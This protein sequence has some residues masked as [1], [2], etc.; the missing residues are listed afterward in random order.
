MSAGSPSDVTEPPGARRIRAACSAGV[1]DD[2]LAA[3]R[4][5]VTDARSSMLGAPVDLAIVFLGSAYADAVEVVLE[6]VVGELRP[7]HV[8]AVT[9]QG[10]VS[11][12]AEVE[13]PTALSVWAAALPGATLEPL[14][15]DPPIGVAPSGAPGWRPPADP[16]SAV[17]LLV[18]PFTFPSDAFL[19]WLRQAR[20]GLPVSGGLASGS[21]RPG[22]NRLHLDGETYRDGA[23]G[24]AIGGGIRARTLVSQGCRPVGTSYVVTDA[25]RNLIRSL[26]GATPVDRVR[27]AFAAATSADRELMRSGL[28]IGAVID[29][30]RTEFGRGDFLVRAVIGAD[31]ASGAIAVGDRVDVG[32]TVQ[33]HVRDAASATEDLLALLSRFGPVDDGAAGLLFTC[34]GRGGRL[35]GV[36]DHDAA[37]VRTALGPLPLAGFFC[38]GE[39]GPIGDRSFLHGFTAS[40]LVLEPLAGDPVTEPQAET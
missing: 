5:A 2:A 32:Q 20:P 9:A 8:L 23:V 24:I 28:Q 33:F 11:D 27:E 18:D 21:D 25:E 29:E 13:R 30:Y 26:G 1:G 7:A 19:A 4:S 6:H 3:A 31:E 12:S 22:G 16:A 39:L 34:N 36:P 15:Y 37:T 38:A 14:R 40:L 10:I 35:F 17:V